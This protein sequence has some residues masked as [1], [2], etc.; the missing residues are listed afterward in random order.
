V[1]KVYNV[2]SM[3]TIEASTGERSKDKISQR[4]VI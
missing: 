3:K 2:F 1:L 4:R